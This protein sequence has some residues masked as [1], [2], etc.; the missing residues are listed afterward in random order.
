MPSGH[1][2]SI[3]TLYCWV[4]RIDPSSPQG[5]LPLTS[6]LPT[7]G[8]CAWIRDEAMVGWGQAWRWQRGKDRPPLVEAGQNAAITEAARVWDLVREKAQIH[9]AEG[10]RDAW[11]SDSP[12]LPI[13]FA[14]CAFED[15]GERVLVVPTFLIITRGSTRCLVT[16]SIDSRAAETLS[17]GPGAMSEKAWCGAVD[18]IIDALRNEEAGKVVMARDMTIISDSP[19]D[20]A[21]LIEHLHQRYPQ[22][23]TFAVAGLIGATPEM[24]VSLHQGKLHSR[25]LAGSSNPEDADSLPLSLKDRSEHLFAV[26]SVVAALLSV[27]QDVQAPARPDVLILPNIAHLSSDVYATFPQGSVLDAVSVIQ[28]RLAGLMVREMANLASP[29]GVAN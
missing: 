14:S 10:T 4:E 5:H 18:E 20:Q 6:F 22:T 9:W 16:S 23:W 13:A 19:F 29:Y 12:V 26:E 3:P 2:S 17:I 8:L 28:A 1:F 24:L 27:A 7:S 21:A 15:D 11:G 25:V